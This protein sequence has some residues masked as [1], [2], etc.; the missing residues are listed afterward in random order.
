MTTS[1]EPLGLRLFLEGIEVPVI[2]ANVDV[3]PDAPAS[4]SIQIIPT[5]LGMFLLPRTLV[6]LFF[7]DPE[8]TEEER[9]EAMSVLQAMGGGNIDISS[10]MEEGKLGAGDFSYKILFTGEITGYSYSKNASQRDLLLQCMDLSSYWDACYQ[11]FA[12]YSH[13]G[14]ALTDTQHHFVAAGE[15]VF[16]NFSGHKWVISQLLNSKPR[17]PEYQQAEGLLGGLIH[18]LEVCGGIRYRGAKFKG[19]KGIND[20]FTVAELRYNL[21]G[22][23]GAIE[24]D[25]TSK[26]LYAK[27]AFNSWLRSGMTSMGTLISFRDILNHVNRWIFHN[28]YPNPCA[29]V[30]A[31]SVKK[32][33]KYIKITKTIMEDSII[34]ETLVGDAKKL[35]SALARAI[36]HLNAALNGQSLLSNTTAAHTILMDN[37]RTIRLLVGAAS[38][39]K[40]D[41]ATEVHK[42]LLGVQSSIDA[43]LT[44]FGGIRV[45]STTG[46]HLIEQDEEPK[47]DVENRATRALKA[48]EEAH[49][50]LVALISP[51]SRIQRSVKK[52][53][54][55]IPQGAHFFNQLF[56]PETFFVSP[57]RCNVI[58][59]DVYTELS[60]SRVFLREVSRLS[61]SSGVGLIRGRGSG[62]FGRSYLAPNIR[63]VRGKLLKSSLSAGTRVILPHELHS[64]IIPVYEWAVDGHRWGAKAAAKGASGQEK[65]DK[66]VHYLQRL[67][68]FQFFLHRWSSR[69]L[70]VSGKFN[71]YVVAGFPGVVIDRSLPSPEVVRVLKEMLGRPMMPIQFIGKVH[72][73][74]HS[75]NQGGGATSVQFVYARTHRGLD[76]ELLHVLS[77]EVYDEGAKTRFPLVEPKR[78]ATQDDNGG[79][80][81]HLFKTISRLSVTGQLKRTTVIRGLG[82]LVQVEE[83]GESWLTREEA[84]ELGISKSYFNANQQWVKF[85]VVTNAAETGIATS[86]TNDDVLAVQGVL[87]LSTDIVATRGLPDDSDEVA[88]RRAIGLPDEDYVQAILSKEKIKI[89]YRSLSRSGRWE[90]TGGKFE[91]IVRPD[92]MSPDVWDNDHITKAVYDHLLGT[93]AITDDKAMGQGD[94]EKLLV[95]LSQ[96]ADPTSEKVQDDTDV[97]AVS[98]ESRSNYGGIFGGKDA[99]QVVP[100]SVEETI[101]GISAVYGLIRAREGNVA[102]FVRIFTRRP[103][104]NIIE[105][106]GTPNLEFTD[107]G[108]VKDS[109]TMREGYHSRAFGD[110]NTDVRLPTKDGET[111][112][113]GKN[114]LAALMDGANART[115]HRDG[116]LQKKKKGTKKGENAIRPEV[117]PRGRARGRV[118]GYVAELSVSRGLS[119]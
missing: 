54:L 55:E 105:I 43:G 66:K 69:Q 57:P 9:K 113:P 27:K 51:K 78:V 53:T 108:K 48:T 98:E 20:F 4:A 67:A 29:K 14:N 23:L 103:I 61:M 77:K 75:L 73:Y 118:R 52:K 44:A 6:H 88:A 99:Y 71:P 65:K 95:Q 102:E 32:T 70:S 72:S 33:T 91:D 85:S 58:F 81:R 12:D 35:L 92:W 2:S 11:Y 7:L 24:K 93:L 84:T 45:D 56:L 3:Q 116:I 82:K 28:I 64:G 10:W 96:R 94:I 37:E 107:D 17:T 36:D 114:A 97:S 74:R 1:A 115:L 76:D 110:Y 109:D 22:M 40:T 83:T 26:K 21:L 49:E 15:G 46:E 89:S 90:R 18:V 25:K 5:D 100:G 19:F 8:I 13:S 59:P 50:T 42:K 68:N 111:V 79:R 63:D 39:M 104:G 47:W 117:D 31:S 80:L 41:D 62:L 60:Y 106:L 16:D 34:G 112:Q 86:S 101:D 38:V 119:G 87:G 30:T